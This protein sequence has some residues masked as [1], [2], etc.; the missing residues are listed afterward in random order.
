MISVKI[1]SKND[2][3]KISEL[4]NIIW[5]ECYKDMLSLEQRNY[6]LDKFL[7]TSSIEKHIEKDNIVYYI[8]Y[9]NNEEAGY[10]AYRN[11]VEHTY[12][13]KLYAMEKFKGK[14]IMKFILDFLNE[15]KKDIKLNTCKTNPTLAIYLHCGFEIIDEQC[16]D[17]GN[18]FFMDDFIL[19]K[20]F[21]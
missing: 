5:H 16:N 14:G 17:I 3:S 18:N 13:C 9:F 12:L 15:F 1:C 10:F 4:S 11:D 6:M 2:S 8:I 7:G 21:K 20:K 19:L